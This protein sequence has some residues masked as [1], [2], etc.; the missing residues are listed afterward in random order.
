V[1]V[2]AGASALALGGFVFFAVDGKDA[3]HGLDACSPR[4]S[5]D[6]VSDVRMRYIAADVLLGTSIVAL[7]LAA[8]LFFSRGAS[9]SQRSFLGVTAASR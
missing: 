7:G 2:A 9:V 8:Y 1:F 3:E 5:D 4:C 6:A